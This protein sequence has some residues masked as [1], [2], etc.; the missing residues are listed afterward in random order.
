MTALS[1]FPVGEACSPHFPRAQE[2][3]ATVLGAVQPA[4]I[5]AS[6]SLLLAHLQ[7][8]SISSHPTLPLS[9]FR[10]SLGFFLGNS[11]F[12]SDLP[13]FRMLGLELRVTVSL[14]QSYLA[15]C[16][17]L[18]PRRKHSTG[19]MLSPTFHT[20]CPLCSQH[21]VGHTLQVRDLTTDRVGYNCL[22]F[23]DPS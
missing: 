20:H 10:Y 21:S 8:A 15:Q 1:V 11:P 23:T 18:S 9:T 5:P 2:S 12:R 14:E 19:H 22:H 17:M 16:G 3:R 7:L 6:D 4:T 13:S